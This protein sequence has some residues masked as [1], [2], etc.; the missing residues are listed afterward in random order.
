MNVELFSLEGSGLKVGAAIGF[1]PLR[2]TVSHLAANSELPATSLVSLD[3]DLW[4]VSQHLVNMREVLRVSVCWDASSGDYRLALWNSD[5]S[6]IH[7]LT[8]G[9]SLR[10]TPLQFSMGGR[11][12][13]A[14]HSELSVCDIPVPVVNVLTLTYGSSVFKLDKKESVLADSVVPTWEIVPQIN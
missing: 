7:S 1:H 14:V 10:A 6:M 11:V 2:E 12:N 5:K 8:A 9:F 3:A 13:L 4:E